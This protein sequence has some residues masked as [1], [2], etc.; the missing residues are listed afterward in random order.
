M[1][2]VDSLAI[3]AVALGSSVSLAQDA[4]LQVEVPVSTG[5]SSSAPNSNR[6]S[7]RNAGRR[8]SSRDRWRRAENNYWRTAS[9][10]RR[11][12]ASA[13]SRSRGNRIHLRD[14]AAHA[15]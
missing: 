6:Y 2:T 7:A 12:V 8:L 9:M 10:L 5:A 1:R 11:M 3:L 14:Q 4:K 15:L 13:L